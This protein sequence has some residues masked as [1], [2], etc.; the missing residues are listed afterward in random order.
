[1]QPPVRSAATQVAPQA[2]PQ[3]PPAKPAVDPRRITAAIKLGQVYLD[4]G[5]YDKAINEYQQGLALDP[6]NQ[7]LK[8]RIA[9]ARR[10][11]SAEEMLNR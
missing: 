10:A 8:E 9:R 6:S 5:E 2:Q 4:R 7:E 1:V 11:K 3:A